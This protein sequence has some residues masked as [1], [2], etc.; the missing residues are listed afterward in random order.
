[1]RRTRYENYREPPVTPRWYVP[2]ARRDLERL[3][4][5]RTRGSDHAIAEEAIAGAEVAT[6]SV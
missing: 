1:M 4:K 5:A 2:L 3:R 6:R